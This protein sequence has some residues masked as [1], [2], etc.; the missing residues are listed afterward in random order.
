MRSPPHHRLQNPASIR[1][2]PHRAV[3]NG[4]AQVVCVA[5]AVAEVVLPIIL[6]QPR[7]LEEPPIVVGRLDGLLRLGI[8]DEDISHVGRELRHVV[9]ELA[10]LCAQ[11]VTRGGLLAALVEFPCSPV[12]QLAA[13]DAAEEEVRAAVI[14]NKRRR[15]DAETTLDVV[16]LGLEGALGLIADGDT[17]AEDTFL[18][19]RGE[20][21]VV[22]PVLGRC[23]G[24]PKL[25]GDPGHVFLL[26]DHA[27]VC[28]G[29]AD[30]FHAEDVVI[31]HVVLIAIVV[32]LG[33]ESE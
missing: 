4:V 10:N 17:H 23:V 18:I 30:L 9:C 22:F 12:L 6:V 31:G 19:T 5:R 1:E 2:R 33:Q 20:V 11:C 15:V 29:P 14:I 3:A 25:F 21:E 26:E 32:A 16:G 27:V 8:K 7:S 13:P 24:G 28:H